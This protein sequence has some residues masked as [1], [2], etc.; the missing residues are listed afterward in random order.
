MG[1]VQGAAR[2]LVAPV[3]VPYP[4]DLSDIID[5]AAGSTQ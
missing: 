1:F 3:S 2:I 4:D 5:L